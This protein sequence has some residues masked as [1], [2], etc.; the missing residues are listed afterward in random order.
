MEEDEHWRQLIAEAVPLRKAAKIPP[1]APRVPKKPGALHSPSP[2][3]AAS[4]ERSPERIERNLLSRINKGR[5]PLEARLDLHGLSEADA[6]AS[7]VAF[8]QQAYGQG[9]RTVL[10]I[11]GKGR[12]GEG[13]LKR[14]FP[15]WLET[16]GIRQ[17]IAGYHSA[18]RSHGGEG[19]WYLRIRPNRDNTV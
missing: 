14:A 10:V 11:T 4:G 19:A 16:D 5:E 13:K 7:L 2:P 15:L 8:L 17:Y 18:S 1:P 6:L 12:G 9:W 3:P